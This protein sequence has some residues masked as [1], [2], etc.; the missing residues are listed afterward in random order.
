MKL[1]EFQGKELFN[2]YGIKIPKS[3]VA[4]TFDQAK[5]GSQKIGFPF[6]LKSQLTVGGRGKA[7][8]IL[9]CKSENELS[10][11]FNELINKEVKG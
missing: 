3:L 9:K 5:I 4:K 2:S 1:L 11:K 10:D 6:V 8:A 7:G